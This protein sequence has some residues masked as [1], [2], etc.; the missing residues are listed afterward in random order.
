MYNQ[1]ACLCGCSRHVDQLQTSPQQKA[2]AQIM[3]NELMKAQKMS[4]SDFS[5]SS[6]SPQK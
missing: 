3:Y 2:Q 1:L 5:I 4:Q 6:P